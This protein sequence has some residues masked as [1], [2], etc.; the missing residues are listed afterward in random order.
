MIKSFEVTNHLGESLEL[1]LA[2]P[3]K[4]GLAVL[5]VTG[6]GQVEADVN[7]TDLAGSDFHTVNS[8]KLTKRNIV[9]KLK[10]WGTDIEE[11][12]HI[13]DKFFPVKKTITFKINTDHRELITEGIVEKNEPDIFSEKSGCQISILCPDPF[14]Y[15]ADTAIIPFGGIEPKFETPFSVEDNGLVDSDGWDQ[16]EVGNIRLIKDKTIYYTGEAETG[17]TIQVDAIDT[18]RT[19][20][21][22]DLDPEHNQ[23]I[24]I[25][26]SILASITGGASISA[27][28]RIIISTVKTQKSAYLIRSGVVYNIINALGMPVQWF[29]LMRGD[30]I[31]SYTASQGEYDMDI[32]IKHRIAYKGI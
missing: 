20:E 2:E 8:A 14:L 18:V 1:I 5:S 27:G 4:S 32:K 30:N 16:F 7:L 9:M 11:C 13:T 28:D 21:F 24:S 6:L 25:D 26:D 29:E 31:F 22:Y 23:K 12:R 19:L 15:S 3:E 10:Y 17:I